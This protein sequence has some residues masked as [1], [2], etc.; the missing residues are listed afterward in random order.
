MDEA[1]SILQS[2]KNKV[3]DTDIAFGMAIGASL[4]S[5][6]NVQNKEF[7]KVKI[8]EIIFQARFG[9]PMAPFVP[10]HM[11]QTLPITFPAG[12]QAPHSSQRNSSDPH[13]SPTQADQL[14]RSYLSQV[15]TRNNNESI[16]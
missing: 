13:I 15:I 7:A 1:M 16:E 9:N 3:Q 8:Q 4:R 11:T 6:S 12:I 14:K 5:I 10:N 2:K